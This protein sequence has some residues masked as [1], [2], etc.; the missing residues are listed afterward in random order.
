MQIQGK[1]ILI[2]VAASLIINFRNPPFSVD[3]LNGIA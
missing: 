3:I 1:A 2:A